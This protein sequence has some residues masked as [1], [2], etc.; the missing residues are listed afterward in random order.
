MSVPRQKWLQ[1]ARE[2]ACE[3]DMQSFDRRPS[4]STGSYWERYSKYKD[5]K[6]SSAMFHRVFVGYVIKDFIAPMALVQLSTPST[7]STGAL[8][9]ES[10]KM[11]IL[12][13]T[14]GFLVGPDGF[15]P[16]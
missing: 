1:P 14:M 5:S 16:P 6:R 9:E 13:A 10:F 4:K 7:N 12:P 8:R 11:G 15:G 3:L 2:C